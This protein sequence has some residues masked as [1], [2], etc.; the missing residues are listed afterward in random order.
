M[1]DLRIRW[2]YCLKFQ[3]KTA[4]KLPCFEVSHFRTE[5]NLVGLVFA[6]DA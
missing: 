5:K 3:H 2:R 1:D 4:G 6:Q